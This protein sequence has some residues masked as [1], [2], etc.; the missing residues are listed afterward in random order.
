MW[1]GSGSVGGMASSVTSKTLSGALWE[2]CCFFFFSPLSFPSFLSIICLLSCS[3]SFLSLT[4][5]LTGF[6]GS[7]WSSL[8]FL[9]L[10]LHP[11]PSWG[12]SE[13]KRLL[14]DIV[15]TNQVTYCAQS[16]HTRCSLSAHQL[17][18]SSCM[19]CVFFQ[20]CTGSP[21]ICSLVWALVSSGVGGNNLFWL[22]VICY[23]RIS[24]LLLG[25]QTIPYYPV[26]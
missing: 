15:F 19:L 18:V 20:S 11:S 16:L 6:Q 8:V 13:P 25:I 23:N 12:P 5:P 21:G 3:H 22:W 17:M 4:S 2:M 26:W 7:Q 14:A 1:V 9:C 10:W 24:L